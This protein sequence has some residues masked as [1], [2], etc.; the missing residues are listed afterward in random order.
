MGLKTSGAYGVVYKGTWGNDDT[1][2]LGI[3][4]CGVPKNIHERC[5][6]FDLFTETFIMDK[7]RNDYR[8]CHLYDFGVDGENYWLIM[9]LYKCSLK[10][11]RVKQ[12]ASLQK[13]LLLY[14][15]IFMNVLNT[16]LFLTENSI[17]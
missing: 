4:L 9:K 5:V 2:E 8:S 12:V 17:T 7:F 13:N 14:L 10:T 11:W 15:N 16:V 6:L 3:K 1:V